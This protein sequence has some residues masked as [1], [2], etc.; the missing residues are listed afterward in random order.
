MQKTL[1]IL[2]RNVQWIALG[3]GGIFLLWAVYSYVVTPPAVASIG[4]V[5]L[6]PEQVSD[7]TATQVAK[8]VQT[9]MSDNADI[10][11]AQLNVA[12]AFDAAMSGSSQTA[13]ASLPA[14]AIGQSNKIGQ[15][16]IEGGPKTGAK[17]TR[18]TALPVLPPAQLVSAQTGLSVVQLPQ[19]NNNNAN[20]NPRNRNAAA[21]QQVGQVE[22]TDWVAVFFKV[23]ADA[24]KKAFDAT[25]NGQ[26]LTPDVYNTAVLE[27]QVQR[28]QAEGMD[29]ITGQPIW[30][31]D[32][33]K[34]EVV[35]ALKIYRQDMKQMPAESAP[36]NQKYEYWDWAEKNP[37]LVYTPEFY[38][39]TGGA[40]APDLNTIYNGDA[41]AN[42]N[43]APN[44]AGGDNAAPDN[45]GQP[46]TPGATQPAAPA[47]GQQSAVPSGSMRYLAGAN[48][49]YSYSPEDEFRPVSGN[50]GRSANGRYRGRPVPP[51]GPGGRFP[52]QQF[53][54]PGQNFNQN[55][56]AGDG[57]IDPLNMGD[58]LKIWAYD[59]T[60]KPGQT[61]R[62]RIV[63]KLR[64]P[65]FNTANLADPKVAARF[66]LDSPPSQWTGPINVPEKTKFWLATLGSNK[67]N[68]DV[69]NF[70]QGQWKKLPP[71]DSSLTPGD[72]VPG[73]DW[74]V[75]DVRGGAE[76]RDRDRYV[77]LTSD[78]GQMSK[79]ELNTD[80]SDPTHQDLLNQTN[81]NNVENG[82]GA[83]TAPPPPSASGRRSPLPSP[84][85]GR[86]SR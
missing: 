58:D 30:P 45:P 63:Y 10:Q 81:P 40:P 65:V 38:Q 49:H 26:Q 29:P 32:D 15:A 6:G 23:P 22:D 59:E 52:Q 3:L 47:S 56:A 44:N 48:P 25:L 34:F 53:P 37:Q 51:P 50:Y 79:R 86:S 85:R 73:T 61:Y 21:V 57:K 41:N 16:N 84:S 70:E 80:R 42:N 39:V 66:A 64:N 77:L 24:I 83:G 2:E 19:A 20:P 74:T 55:F 69:F 36:T 14:W 82:N 18:I 9:A 11:I 28:Q 12:Q 31:K 13:V 33:N 1:D 78:T 46:A 75:V 7:A 72:Q 17:E 35:P 8:N 4:P 68:L 43:A 60:A 27:V 67:A 5:K 54:V 71:K 62:Y 76:G